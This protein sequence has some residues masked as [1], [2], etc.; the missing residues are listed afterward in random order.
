MHHGHHGAK[1]LK[2]RRAVRRDPASCFSPAI[3]VAVSGLHIP[4]AP[5][6]IQFALAF[7]NNDRNVRLLL[8][9]PLAIT[10]VASKN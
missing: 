6:G 4:L 8:P 3:P 1:D 7:Q 5:Q 9:Q 2:A 10:W